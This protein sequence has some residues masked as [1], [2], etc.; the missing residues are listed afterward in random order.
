MFKIGRAR[1]RCFGILVVL[2]IV[3]AFPAFCQAALFGTPDDPNDTLEQ[4]L[5]IIQGVDP[6]AA[7]L[8]RQE[9]EPKIQS[10][11]NTRLYRLYIKPD[12]KAVNAALDEILSMME[13][14][15]GGQSALHMGGVKLQELITIHGQ[16]SLGD[17]AK[18]VR[19]KSL[20]NEVHALKQ[21]Y[22]RLQKLE[23][24][25]SQILGVINAWV[26]PSVGPLVQS[27]IRDRFLHQVNY[28]QM[29]GLKAGFGIVYGG[30]GGFGIGKLQTSFGKNSVAGGFQGSHSFITGPSVSLTQHS[31]IQRGNRSDLGLSPDDDR[32]YYGLKPLLAIGVGGG[33]STLCNR[34]SELIL[35]EFTVCPLKINEKS[36]LKTARLLPLPGRSYKLVRARLGISHSLTM[37]IFQD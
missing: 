23:L 35:R 32:D 29:S 8:L 34:S 20:K 10:K 31:G 21:A 36:V 30:E 11:E 9:Y 33:E 17:P 7:E 13:S 19:L 18:L 3:N 14:G 15:R 27:L 22:S 26:G 25:L 28:I 1:Y 2:V 12:K 24:N 5:Q 6:R 37:S 16:Y 4:T